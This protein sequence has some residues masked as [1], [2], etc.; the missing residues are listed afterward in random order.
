VLK[1]EFEVLGLASSFI[2][3]ATAWKLKN[4][5]LI[6]ESSFK[7]HYDKMDEKI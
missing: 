2:T 4:K 6:M 5:A 1:L 7:E 3:M